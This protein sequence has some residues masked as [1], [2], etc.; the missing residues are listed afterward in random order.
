MIM[1]KLAPIVL[2]IY[3]RPWHTA[4]T[5]NALKRNL[6]ANESILYIFADGPKLDATDIDISKIKET[7]EFIRKE[8]WCK[9]VIIVESSKNRGLGTSI[10][11]GVTEI[12]KKHGK[13]I[14]LE[15]DLITSEGFLKF[16]NDALKTY[17]SDVKVMHIGTYIP[18]FKGQEKLPETFFLEN[19]SCLGWSTWKRA[20]DNYNHD[21]KTLYETITKS[22]EILYKF[23]LDGVRNLHPQLEN[24]LLGKSNTWAINWY[25]TIF[26]ANGLC[27]YPKQAMV[28]HIGW[29]GSGTNTGLLINNIYKVD[30]L[31]TCEVKKIELGI[32][33]TARKYIK[34]FHKSLITPPLKVKIKRKVKQILKLIGLLK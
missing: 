7:R 11:Q 3:N 4:Q 18:K 19:M 16:H 24:N 30:L 26:F 6:L 23:N 21:T 10:H 2:F 13:V 14:V 31:R 9:D 20:W 28:E 1:S 25:A 33:K 12:I 17:E 32:S 27:L 29:D 34:S 8:K 15:D 22:K 5:L